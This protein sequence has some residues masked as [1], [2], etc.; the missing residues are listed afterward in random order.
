LNGDSGRG[1]QLFWSTAVKCGSCHQV[2]ERGTAIGP[3][4]TRIGE[5]RTPE[6]LLQSILE[7]SRRIEPKYSSYLAQTSD[8]RVLTGVLLKRDATQV[9]LRDAENKLLTLAAQDV[10]Q[11]QPSRVSMM[12][13]GQLAGLS[14]QD[15]A[16]LLAYLASRRK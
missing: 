1:E 13:D 5:Q 7:P 11:L 2:G 3:E 9:V 16:D 12:A 10:T 14:A 15:A 4:L 8:G 6:D